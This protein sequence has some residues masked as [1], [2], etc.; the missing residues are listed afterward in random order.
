MMQTISENI[1]DIVFRSD[2]SII[3]IGFNITF[4]SIEGKQVFHIL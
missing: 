1:A 2:F 3:K 4:S